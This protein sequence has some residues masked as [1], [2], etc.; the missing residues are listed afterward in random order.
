MVAAS[1]IDRGF[2]QGEID[3]ILLRGIRNANQFERETVDKVLRKFSELRIG[4]I[5]ARLRRLQEQQRENGHT[6]PPFRW[7][8]TLDDLLIRVHEG[9]GLSAA[10]SGV[11]SLTG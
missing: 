2:W 1:T 9:A 4:V 6:G 11:E 5:W 8:D 7:T 3:P 10:V